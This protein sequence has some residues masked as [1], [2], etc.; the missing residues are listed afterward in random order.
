MIAPGLFGE[1][2]VNWGSEIISLTWQD[3]VGFRWD[4]KGLKAKKTFHYAGEGWALTQDGQHLIMSDGTPIIR[5]RR[6]GHLQGGAPHRG[7]R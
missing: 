3:K 1:G 7:H 4:L 2:I 6:P 5:F